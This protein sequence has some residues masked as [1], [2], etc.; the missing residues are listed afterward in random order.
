MKLRV[1]AGALALGLGASALVPA[2][3]SADDR[4]WRDGRDR[5]RVR[6]VRSYRND[7]SRSY[8][9]YRSDRSYRSYNSY[10]PYRYSG[11]TYRPYRSYRYYD[12]YYYDDYGYGGYYGSYGSYGYYEP[13]GYRPRVVVVPSYRYRGYRPLLGLRVGGPRFGVWLGF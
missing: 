6:I 12:D 9:S 4:G 2:V 3:A 13:Y 10:R 1:L 7:R 5:G 8:R 11:Y